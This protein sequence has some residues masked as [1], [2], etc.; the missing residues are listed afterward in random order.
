[1]TEVIAEKQAFVQKRSWQL[2]Q[3]PIGLYLF[4]E[5]IDVERRQR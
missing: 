4:I 3:E 2:T 1:M 5:R